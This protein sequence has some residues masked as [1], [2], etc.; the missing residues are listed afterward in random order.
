[1]NPQ[2]PKKILFV[3]DDREIAFIYAKVL[4]SFGFEVDCAYDGESGLKQAQDKPYD[5]VLLDLM[6]PNLSGM[7]VLKV[8]RNKDQSPTFSANTQII[9]LTNF[10]VD[11]I[12]KKELLSMAQAYLIKV[13]ITPR[14]LV[15]ILNGESR[16]DNP[17]IAR[18]A[19]NA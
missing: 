2:L 9:I 18:T 12:M 13:N 3:E 7:D 11:D 8:L 5:I 14:L 6:L 15:G 19:I 1:M 10:E 16:P 17:G 4:R